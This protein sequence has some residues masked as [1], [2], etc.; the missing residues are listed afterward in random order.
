MPLDGWIVERLQGKVKGGELLEISLKYEE[1]KDKYFTVSM[2]QFIKIK[3]YINY[4]YFSLWEIT[5][6]MDKSF[7]KMFWVQ[8]QNKYNLLTSKLSEFYLFR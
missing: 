4:R 6:E 5:Y 8:K 2:V 1:Q 3:I 7:L